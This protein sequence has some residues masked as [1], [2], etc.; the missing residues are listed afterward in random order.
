M[1]AHRTDGLV[2]IWVRVPEA[3]R[4]LGSKGRTLERRIRRGMAAGLILTRQQGRHPEV[5]WE[6]VC[7][8]HDEG[9]HAPR[10]RHDD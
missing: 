1:G 6:S 9:R 7:D 4:L 2:S 5:W 10:H 3:A 8:W